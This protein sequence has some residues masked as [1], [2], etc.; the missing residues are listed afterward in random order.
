MVERGEG[1]NMEGG[2]GAGGDGEGRGGGR[3]EEGEGVKRSE[4]EKEGGK[5]GGG[6]EGERGRRRGGRGKGR[7]GM[8]CRNVAN[9]MTSRAGKGDE[10]LLLLLFVGLHTRKLNCSKLPTKSFAKNA[11]A[12]AEKKKKT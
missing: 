4:K 12:N 1:R 7:R 9:T 3:G 11:Q 10:E 8:P 2:G 5:G 6:G